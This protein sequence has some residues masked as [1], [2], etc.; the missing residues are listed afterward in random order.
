MI[1][2]VVYGFLGSGK[3]TFIQNILQRWGA[4]ERIVVLVNEFGD[5]G[6]DGDLLQDRNGHIVE[7]P[8][9]CIC[10]T[11]QADFRTQMLDISQNIKPQRVVIEPTG[12]AT[13]K[14]IQSIIQAEIFQ[15]AIQKIHNIFIADA[16]TLMDLYKSNRHFVESQINSAHLALLNKCDLVDKK[17]AQLAKSVI[18]SINPSISVLASE[19]GKVDW[20]E[21]QAALTAHGDIMSQSEAFGAD[22]LPE[23]DSGPVG[24]SHLHF[25]PEQDALG[26]ESMGRVYSNVLFQKPKL[27]AFFQALQR[28]E[29]GESIVRAKGIFQLEQGALLL[30]LASGETSTQ[31]VQKV[32]KS[33]ISII[34][35]GLYQEEIDRCLQQCTQ[36][37]N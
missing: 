21:Y 33:K 1:V 26:Y 19:Y 8:S 35:R 16:Q 23:Y 15:D 10:C 6:I 14:Q 7:M 9:G 25:H 2:D 11:L 18:N 12:V 31:P 28:H 5:I 17:K 37:T 24:E 3:T 34:G 29:L 22:L 30:E 32:S 36:E 4:L 27:E 13:I 20:N